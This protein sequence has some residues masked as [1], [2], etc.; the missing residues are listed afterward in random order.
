MREQKLNAIF[1][2]TKRAK[3]VYNR[4]NL[5]LYVGAKGKFNVYIGK[6][7]VIGNLTLKEL[8]EFLEG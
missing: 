8:N 2:L 6:D 5:D 1:G 3:E 4:N 7:Y